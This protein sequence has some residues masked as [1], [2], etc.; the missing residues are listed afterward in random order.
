MT[1]TV[2]RIE[3][4]KGECRGEIVMTAVL[5]NGSSVQ[6]ITYF[7]DEQYFHLDDMDKFVGGPVEAV[8]QHITKALR[9]SWG[10]QTLS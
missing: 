3:F 9:G 1:Q 5:D 6:L 4:A 10:L 7:D 2:Q 8:R